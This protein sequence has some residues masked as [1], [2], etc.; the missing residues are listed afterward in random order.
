MRGTRYAD[1]G[2]VD[3]AQLERL[4]ELLGLGRRRAVVV[5]AD[6][7]HG[8]RGDI[9]D[10]GDRRTL[11][12]VL[13][14]FPWRGREPVAREERIE[15]RGQHETRPV[16]HRLDR[17]GRAEAVGVADDP[18]GQAAATAAAGDEQV[19]GIDRAERDGRVD[20]AHQVV[21]ILARVS[22]LDQVGELAAVARAAAR[23]GI[24]H[25]I[26][27]RRIKLDL[28]GEGR[29]VGGERA[30]VDLEQQRVL[31]RRVEVRRAH[32]P[33][34]DVA[35]VG[36]GLDRKFLHL[37]EGQVIEQVGVEVGQHAGPTRAFDHGQVG[38]ALRRAARVGGAARGRREAGR[39]VGP[40]D[41]GT[42]K[43]VGDRFDLA[44]AGRNPAEPGAP[45]IVVLQPEATVAVPGD[46]LDAEVDAVGQRA[47]VARIRVADID[48]TRLVGMAL[49]VEAE[50][51]QLL[52]V[53]GKGRLAVGTLAL[54]QAGHRAVA[55]RHAIQ[56]AVE[57]LVF[58][59]V[60]E[61]GRYDQCLA[62]AR[63]CR[64]AIEIVL[65]AG[66]LARRAAFGRDHEHM[67]VTGVD[68]AAAIDPVDD[69][70]DDLDRRCPFG[71]LRCLRH[72]RHLRVLGRHAHRERQPLT[73]RRPAQVARRLGQFADARGLA[74][75]HPVHLDLR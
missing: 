21:E 5:V 36:R 30:T 66:D 44:A 54:G 33:G 22:V 69:A 73:V 15:I 1:H 19:V 67:R 52:A 34:L 70:V 35:T 24:D 28:R 23:I 60:I 14:V 61:V 39:S 17:N 55:D 13:G 7:H 43:V 25:D 63:P 4:V 16:D 53:G 18:R 6:H 20:H 51:G 58:P 56:L 38:Q 31:L 10:I 59:V 32:D 11:H 72:G 68:V 41:L 50:P 12:V 2:G 62:V 42:A 65:A 45:M 37:A 75:V 3:L 74:A 27:G 64:P 57:R 9:A 8:R 71:A 46:R 40:A 26:A 29:S 48:A 49:V 47:R